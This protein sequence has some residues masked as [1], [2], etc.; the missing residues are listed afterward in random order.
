M[1]GFNITPLNS[2]LEASL[3]EKINLKTKP[4]GALGKLEKLALQ[5]GKIQNTLSPVLAQPTIVVFAGD[6]GIA[7]EGVSPYPQEVT[8]QMVFNF[9]Q[10]GAGINVFARQHQIAIKVVDAGVNYTFAPHPDLIDLKVAPG[11]Q[12][13]LHTPAMSVEECDTAISRAATLVAQLH[14]DGC[15]VIGFGEMGIGNTS[16]AAMLMSLLCELP[17][18]QCIGRGTGLDD[19]GLEKK[20]A[21]LSEALRTQTPADK[22]PLE[23]LRTFGGFEVAMI[24]GA[25]LKAAELKMIVLVDGFITTA[26][27]LVAAALHPAILDYC[28]FAHQSNEQGHQ[29]LLTYLKADPLLQL[30]MRLGE[31]TGAAVAYP[32]VQSA[33]AFLNEM[34]SFA[35][36][37]VSNKD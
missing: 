29:Q 7:K 21:I 8:W 28:V 35:S 6:H 36:A 4:L 5:I 27:L 16:S 30:G 13:Y 9:L 14:K 34:A 26:A 25:M 37:G 11:T 15:N 24:C 22:S 10:G 3:T 19:K 12:S 18:E 1:T 20:K 23:I 2:G 31:G 33:V 32:L 17:L